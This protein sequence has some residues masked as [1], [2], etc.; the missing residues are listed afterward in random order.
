MFILLPGVLHCTSWLFWHVA[1]LL[2]EEKEYISNFISH[3]VKIFY[4]WVHRDK[5]PTLGERH[6][7][8]YT[9]VSLDYALLRSEN[10]VGSPMPLLS[11]GVQNPK[12][13]EQLKS[14][15]REWFHC[16]NS[17]CNVIP[18]EVLS[19]LRRKVTSWRVRHLRN[20]HPFSFLMCNIWRLKRLQCYRN[21]ITEFLCVRMYHLSRNCL[22]YSPYL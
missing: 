11:T 14:N 18:S 19:I 16:L 7:L 5:W 2:V 17:I 15:S 8:L 22:F 21:V 6:A 3:C 13:M 4:P 1:D 12:H 20:Q 10:F 9:I